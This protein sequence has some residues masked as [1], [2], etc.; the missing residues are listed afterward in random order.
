[1]CFIVYD[2]GTTVSTSNGSPSL[3]LR[4]IFLVDDIVLQLIRRKTTET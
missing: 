2:S 1:M 4:L 3:L